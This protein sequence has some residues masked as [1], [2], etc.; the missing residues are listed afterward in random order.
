[1]RIDV[2]IAKHVRA[3][4]RQFDLAIKFSADTTRLALYGPSGAGKTLTLQ[5]L[6][7][8][9][10]PDKGR[11]IVDDHTWFDAH[12]R[13]DVPPRGRRIGYVFQDY[14][15][16]PHWTVAQNVSSAFA[17]GWPRSMSASQSRRVERM[18]ISFD[19]ADIR[20][21]YPSQI[22]GGQR[23]RT[24]V[25][26]ALV[27]RPR[28]LMLD[29]PFAALDGMLKNRLRAELLAI[30]DHYDIPMILITHDPDDL[31]ACADVVVSLDGGH[32]V[33]VAAGDRLTPLAAASEA[34][35]ESVSM[36][37]DGFRLHR[38]SAT[39]PQGL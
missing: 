22:S 37:A 39:A 14:A 23:Q 31:T 35:A 6:A 28:I 4:G 17:R 20:D 18:L 3:A 8:L 38:R 1:M 10:R 12:Q 21:S 15:L 25:A 26:R 13:V 11:I 19:L 5:M 16:F 34:A 36:S 9:V 27:D 32:V 24:A 2:D 29:E 33:A 7:G 30:Q